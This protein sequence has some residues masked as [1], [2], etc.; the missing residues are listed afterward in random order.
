MISRAKTLRWRRSAGTA[1][2]SGATGV[3]R[4]LCSARVA[5]GLACRWVAAFFLVLVLPTVRPLSAQSSPSREM[6]GRAIYAAACQGCHAPDGR[7]MPRT[8]VGFAEV[9]PDFTDCS[10]ASREAAQDWETIVREG[11][12][13][14]RFSRRMPS[15]GGALSAEQI[16]RVVA[17]VQS[18]CTD[19]S[20]PRG[21]LNLPR[22]MS[23][24]KAFPE[25]EFVF[26]STWGGSRGARVSTNEFFFEKRIGARTQWEVVVPMITQERA[27]TD[28]GG[29][30]TPHLGDMEL[31]IKRDVHH[32]SSTILSLGGEL[33]V[34]SGDR[35][36]G[37]GGGTW[38]IEPYVLS[39]AA[40][41]AN[42]FFQMQSGIELPT[43]LARAEREWYARGALGTTW[44]VGGRTVS[45][46]V[47]GSVARAFEGGESAS[48]D[49]TPQV[50]V[51]L[52]RRRHILAS[53]G[54]RMP[55]T[56]RATRSRELL[57]YFLWDWFDGPLLGAW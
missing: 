16:S 37:Y 10:Y 20:W 56:E 15:F 43:N 47:E 8:Q 50:Q 13:I 14:R 30:T 46:M 36:A 5:A 53:V 17:Y 57:A 32:S 3:G 22:S 51:S 7:G 33:L 49:W 18:L 11:G 34:P 41:P 31:A 26:T 1:C 25:D 28:G 45:P 12:P 39:G 42:S 23:V 44:I 2:G 27:A 19:A 6:S 9:L 40:L 4:D 54:M 52:S 48:Y 35:K 24:E 38:V 21:E 29:W 55:I